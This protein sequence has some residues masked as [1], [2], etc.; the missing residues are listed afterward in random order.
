MYGRVAFNKWNGSLVFQT[1][2]NPN[3]NTSQ[4]K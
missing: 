4:T 3:N 2:K 1:I